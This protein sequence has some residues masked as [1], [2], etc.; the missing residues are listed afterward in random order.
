MLGV[1]HGD[2]ALNNILV[3]E[4]EVFIIDFGF[5]EIDGSKEKMEEEIEELKRTLRLLGDGLCRDSLGLRFSCTQLLSCNYLLT[6]FIAWASHK[7]KAGSML[8]RVVKDCNLPMNHVS[9]AFDWNVLNCNELKQ[10]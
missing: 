4:S 7:A 9:C 3:Q 2:P 8:L 10:F 1:C 6:R 5:S